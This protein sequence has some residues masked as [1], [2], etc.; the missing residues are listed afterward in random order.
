MDISYNNATTAINS[1][2]LVR[3]STYSINMTDLFII[4]K[5]PMTMQK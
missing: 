4:V 2:L 5:I 3:W 1:E